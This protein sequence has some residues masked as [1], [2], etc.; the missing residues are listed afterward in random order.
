MLFFTQTIHL[1][2]WNSEFTNNTYLPKKLMA[3][4]NA[5]AI[6]SSN[7]LSTLLLNNTLKR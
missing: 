5:K 2:E 4:K 3:D 6:I 1:M 7:R